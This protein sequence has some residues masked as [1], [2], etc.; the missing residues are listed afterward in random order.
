M[1]IALENIAPRDIERRSFE[2]ITQELGDTP[3]IPGT[4]PIVKRCIHTSADFDYAQNLRFSQNVVAQAL[5]AIRSGASIITDTKMAA[6]GINQTALAR[7]GGKVCCF[8]LTRM[9][10]TL[11]LPRGLP[12]LWQP[13]ISPPHW[14]RTLFMPSET[15]L[16]PLSA[17]TS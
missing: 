5:D 9:W 14:A 2:I 8:I 6:S 17:C 1:K 16:L 3:L 13:W 11:P 12:A 4:E 15:P 10:S 7:Y